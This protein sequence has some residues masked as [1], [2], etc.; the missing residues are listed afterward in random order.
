M[1]K[2]TQKLNILTLRVAE[3]SQRDFGRGIARIDPEDMQKINAGTGDVI[4][5]TGKKR[6]A[7]KVMPAY[8]ENRGKG[9][10][11]ID[12]LTRNNALFGIDDKVYVEKV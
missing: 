9:L 1:A 8:P 4:L 10:I 2:H 6:T 11:Q 5:I 12:G 7:A 3:A